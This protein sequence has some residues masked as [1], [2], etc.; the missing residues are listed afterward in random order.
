MN[1]TNEETSAKAP[2]NAESRLGMVVE[3]AKV[4]T[5]TETENVEEKYAEALE[6]AAVAE[7]R[8]LRLA[9]EF[10]NYKKR[11]EREK[12]NVLKYAEENILKELLP[13]LDNL[14]RAIEQRQN[15][16]NSQ[17]FFE[18][19]VMIRN[20]LLST[21]NKFGLTPLKS[22]GKPFDPHFHEAVSV[23][24]SDEVPENHVLEEYQKGYMLKDRLIRPAKVIVSSGREQS[25]SQ[26]Y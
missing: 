4:L 9:A 18:G 2:K 8:L 13:S 16:D 7:D 22:L 6:K 12:S 15:A 14:D 20:N 11:V 24:R 19:V 3:K 21:L 26:L 25:V 10:E 23:G 5:E 17:N 1:I